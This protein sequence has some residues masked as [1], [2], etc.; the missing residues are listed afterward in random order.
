[1]MSYCGGRRAPSVR[2]RIVVGL[3][4]YCPV[5]VTPAAVL[6]MRE[7]NGGSKTHSVRKNT[8]TP[9]LS[10]RPASSPR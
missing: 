1:M 6:V 3:G 2:I 10:L 5:R 8:H 4:H 9:T 7:L